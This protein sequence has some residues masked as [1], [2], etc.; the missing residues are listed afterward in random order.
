MR[1]IVAKRLRN[2]C[3]LNFFFSLRFLWE[4]TR[5]VVRGLGRQQTY[6]EN[7]SKTIKT[8]NE[9]YPIEIYHTCQSVVRFVD[10]V[11]E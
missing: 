11:V 4:R 2:R 9:K 10:T 1:N 7:A 8:I 6:S 3:E 5:T